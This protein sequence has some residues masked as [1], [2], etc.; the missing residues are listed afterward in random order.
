[1]YLILNFEE[2]NLTGYENNRQ[3]EIIDMNYPNVSSV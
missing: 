2:M 3:S 1:M